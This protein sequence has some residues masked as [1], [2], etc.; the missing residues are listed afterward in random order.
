MKLDDCFKRIDRYLASETEFA[1]RFVNVQNVE[2]IET[3]R[4]HFSVGSNQCISVAAY[5]GKD[6]NLRIYELQNALQ[7]K[8]GNVF[9]TGLSTQL[10]LEG[11]VAIK[12]VLQNMAQSTYPAHIVVLCYQCKDYLDFADSRLTRL[13]Y[14]VEGKGS[15]IPQLVFTL[16]EMPVPPDADYVEGVQ[17]IAENIEKMSGGKLYVKTNK[18]K[19]N[20]RDS[21]FYIKEEGNAFEVL[22]EIDQATRGLS[23]EFG[24]DEQWASALQAVNRASSWGNLINSIFGGGDLSLFVS[25]WKSFDYEKKWLYFIA[26]KLNGAGKDWCLGEAIDTTSHVDKLARG[27]YRT[28]LNVDYTEKDFWKK[29]N[30]RKKIIKDMGVNE[31]EVL[32]YLQMIQYRE[33]YAIYYLTDLSLGEKEKIL[34]LLSTY[35][36]DFSKDEVMS[37]LS[38]VYLD[39]Y[40]YLQPYRFRNEQMF[41]YFQDYKYQKVINKIDS[42]FKA[43]VEEQAK[44]RDFNRW[45][46]PRSEKMEKLN[47]D[48]AR[49]Y[50]VDAMGV[51]YLSFIME[52]CRHLKLMANITICH[53]ELPSITKLNKEFL[54]CFTDVAPDVKR[55]DAIKHHGEES[56][57]YRTTKLPLH[58]IRELEIIDEVLNDIRK[59]LATGKNERAY[60]IS[61]H[62]ASRLAVI[63]ENECQ[64]EMASKGEHSGRCC[65][66]SETDV[67]SEYAMEANDFWVL[68][69]YDRFKGGRKASVEVHGGATLEEVTVPII[70]F[71]YIVDEIEV[72][73][74]SKLLIEISFRKKAQ[75]QLFSKTKLSDVTV[76]V[77]GKKLENKFYD[78]EP[79]GN[80]LYLVKMPDVKTA[81]DYYMIVY[82]NN[83]QVAELEFSVKKESSSERDIL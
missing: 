73:I 72:S 39:L 16:P 49:L 27:V 33:K 26:L 44:T 12:R 7:N 35:G 56:F 38:H 52:R 3:F 79:Q 76:C 8:L 2:D 61:D 66:K 11:E 20:Y 1:P 51:E 21:L 30:E 25:N 57:D 37:I 45:L 43:V 9:L 36:Q 5:A 74:K 60:I 14:D 10:K 63:N 69:N 23:A 54:D 18:H 40:A 80:N 41:L 29:Y 42:A 13:V 68:A 81:G 6:E 59:R 24:T 67:Y 83:N 75:I 31:E 17:N 58:L 32:D 65:P 77:S 62:G 46:P 34:E 48:G 4:Q 55:L 19:S 28:I 47:K 15:M 78:A 50:F 53:C 82:S 64:W 71:T 70:E 22:C